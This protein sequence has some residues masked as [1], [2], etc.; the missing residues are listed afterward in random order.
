MAYNARMENY[1]TSTESLNARKQTLAGRA[2]NSMVL[3][4]AFAGMA[5]LGAA[6][7]AV[8]LVGGVFGAPEV[9][10]QGKEF[11]RFSPELGAR[12]L[13]VIENP[14]TSIIG[15]KLIALAG[16]LGW[17][18]QSLKQRQAEF[19][20]DEVNA[21]MQAK[22]IGEALGISKQQDRSVEAVVDYGIELRAD[23]RE[24]EQAR[25]L[26]PSHSLSNDRGV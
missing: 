26:D 13:W 8:A 19:A 25:R 23:W 16:A 4:Y 10:S 6:A 2:F 21:Q 22:K 18:D 17:R 11:L 15:G 7:A 12:S 9:I 20:I 3:K 14:I 1:P 5:L 24:R